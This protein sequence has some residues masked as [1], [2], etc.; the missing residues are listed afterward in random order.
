M[1]NRVTLAGNLGR[2]PELVRTPGGRPVTNLSLATH[3]AW[4][5]KEGQRRQQTEWHH[6]VVW[7]KRAERVVARLRKGALVY[8][9]GRLRTRC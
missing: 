3:E 7:G 2:D 6:V 8:I 4:T 1:L 5:D 9:T